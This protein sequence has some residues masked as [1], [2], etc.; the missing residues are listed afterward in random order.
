MLRLRAAAVLAA[1][2]LSL[3]GA[4]VAR[5]DLPVIYDFNVGLAASIAAPGSSP[6]GANDWSCQPTAAH[7]RPVVLVHGT[8]ENQRNNWNALSPLLKN[9]GYCVFTLT[10]GERIPGDQIGGIRHVPESAQQLNAFVDRVLAATG[11]QEVDLVGHSQGGMMPRWYIKFLGGASEV[12]NLIGLAP[13]NHG[14]TLDGLALLAAYFPGGRE[15]VAAGCPSCADQIVG[16][17]VLQALNSGDET[18]DGVVYTV[19]QT[20][21]DQV[22]TPYTSAFL[23]GAK[24]ILLQ[25][26]CILDGVEHLGIS[27]DHIALRDVLNALDPANARAPI[28]Y[29]VL[30][31][32]GG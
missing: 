10:Y 19:I 25:N 4:S 18:P 13:S 3:T 27:Y 17:D 23:E 14:T 20:K 9:H 29:P 12:Y 30:P 8:F 5:A 1:V 26:Q 31:E 32:R 2:V 7:P 15:T 22:V 11:A 24:N 16:S 28:C 21:Y 6:P